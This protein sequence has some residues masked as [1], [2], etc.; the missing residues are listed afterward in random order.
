VI[1]RSQP[2]LTVVPTPSAL[3]RAIQQM[4]HFGISAVSKAG[5]A[6]VP[7]GPEAFA[8]D[9]FESSFFIHIP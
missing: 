5:R 3:V 8:R 4:G 6:D 7:I 9:R 2:A 1:G